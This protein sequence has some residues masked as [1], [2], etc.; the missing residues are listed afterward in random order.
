MALVIGL[1][2]TASGSP[3]LRARHYY[4]RMPTPQDNPSGQS[5]T[6]MS[7]G[8]RVC[9]AF[10]YGRG[11][12][13]SQHRGPMGVTETP[14]GP[15]LSGPLGVQPKEGKCLRAE[16]PAQSLETNQCTAQQHE[17]HA[18]VGYRPNIGKLESVLVTFEGDIMERLISRD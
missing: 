6:P 15:D 13:N 1:A 4:S 10:G 18:A 3:W 8:A 17:S 7:K 9:L 2:V 16:L 5:Q 11:G 12:E 14:R